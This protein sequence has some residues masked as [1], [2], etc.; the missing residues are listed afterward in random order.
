MRIAPRW[1]H[2]SGETVERTRNAATAF[3]GPLVTKMF[4]RTSGRLARLQMA[5]PRCPDAFL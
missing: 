1:D 5:A 3:S 2:G 4:F